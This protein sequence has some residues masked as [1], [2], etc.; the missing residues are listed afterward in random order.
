M[1][2]AK[3]LMEVTFFSLATV[4]LFKVSDISIEYKMKRFQLLQAIFAQNELGKFE[5][6]LMRSWNKSTQM[7]YRLFISLPKVTRGALSTTVA[8]PE[9]S[10][11]G[12]Q[13][14]TE[15]EI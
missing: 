10:I 9:E 7:G 14:Q 8:K 13:E 1:V 12:I 11:T 15:S 3:V 4:V 2:T 6:Y 5:G